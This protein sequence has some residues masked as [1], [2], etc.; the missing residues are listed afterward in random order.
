MSRVLGMTTPVVSLTGAKVGPVSRGVK[1]STRLT[2][3]AVMVRHGL[4]GTEG[5]AHQKLL[6]LRDELPRIAE[7]FHVAGAEAR[8]VWWLE[9]LDRAVDPGQPALPL[10]EAELVETE[11]DGDEDTLRA[12]LRLD[13]S[14]TNRR[15]WR[16]AARRH[17][18]RLQLLL[19]AD[20]HGASQ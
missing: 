1:Y 4:A 12:K 6:R 18:A 10:L 8:L 5:S 17:I 19:R 20:E 14:E 3:E 9:P 13:P 2:V 11:A 7:S 16:K 15:E